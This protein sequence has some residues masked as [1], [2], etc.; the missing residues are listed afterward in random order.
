MNRIKAFALAGLLGFAAV[1]MAMGAPVTLNLAFPTGQTT[2]DAQKDI[3]KA[4][5]DQ[6]KGQIK[7]NLVF[8]PIANQSAFWESYFDK[9]QTMIASGNGPDVV[10]IAIEGIQTFVQRGLALP[11]DD[12][13]KAEPKAVGDFAD[14]P[15]LLQA[16]FVV[17][18]KTYGFAHDWN[19][20]VIHI[21][22]DLLKAAKLPMPDAN[23][24]LEDFRRYAKAMTGT[25]NGQKTYGFAIPNYYFGTSGWLFAN[26]AGVLTEDQKKG[27]L[28]SPEAMQVIQ[29]F[30][31]MIYK[32]KVSPVPDAQTDPTTLLYTG[33]VGMIAA[34]R[35]PFG[36]YAANK[37][38][39]VAL[40]Y[41]PLM[42]KPRSVVFG[43]AGFPVLSSTAHP[44]EAY[45]LSAFM[46]GV[47]SIQ[48]G[49][50]IEGIPGRTS[51]MKSVLPSTQGQNWQIFLDSTKYAKAVQSPPGY[52]E[53]ASIFD[54]Y[55]SSV[56]AD[57]LD[58][59]TAMKKASEE[60]SQV[61]SNQ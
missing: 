50:A 7:V 18:G 34:G 13:I 24:S 9:I 59:P 47:L 16:P 8:V 25:F 33:K 41:V 48:K 4:F 51:V 28:D 57:Q 49:V 30:H 37:F 19:N 52:P 12:F 35:W 29:L 39:S 44:K 3:I 60:I 55:T 1:S 38:K 56:Y 36:T 54:R 61:L 21:N 45:E 22:T 58:V 23:W 14:F 26:G 43:V 31:D 6:Y 27:A 11:L 40:Q 20:I 32:D 10:L 15:P 46:S 2:L 53:V 5:E 42:K 17:D